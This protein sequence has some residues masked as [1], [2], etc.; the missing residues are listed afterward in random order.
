LKKRP[1]FPILAACGFAVN[2]LPVAATTATAATT[3]SWPTAT[4]FAWAFPHASARSASLA[5]SWS[6]ILNFLVVHCTATPTPA[7]GH[8]A[9]TLWSCLIFSW[10]VFTPVVD[11]FFNF[12]SLALHKCC[13]NFGSGPGQNAAG[14]G[15]GNFHFQAN[16]F[17]GQ[18]FHVSQT[19]GFQL[20]PFQD[21]FL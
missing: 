1:A 4:A 2:K 14:G 12:D 21:Y 11:S 6:I 5:G 10:H 20:I 16:V 9:L 7:S 18:S 17:M 19:K 13:G 8:G 15:S 3:S